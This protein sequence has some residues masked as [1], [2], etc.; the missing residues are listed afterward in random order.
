[1]ADGAVAGAPVL[2]AGPDRRARLRLPAWAVPPTL[3]GPVAGPVVLAVESAGDNAMDLLAAAVVAAE[4]AGDGARPFR[5]VVGDDQRAAEPA[6]ALARAAVAAGVDA[7][8]GHFSSP[9][10][11]AVAPIYGA[12]GIPFFAPGS[13]ANDLSDDPAAPVIQPFA[14]DGGQV[15]VLADAMAAHGG[16]AAIVAQTGNAGEA[17]GRA[18][19]ERLTA[20]GRPALLIPAEAGETAGV[21]TGGR[22]PIVAVLGSKEFA[23]DWLAR[24][25]ARGVGAVLLSDDSDGSTAVAA[26]LDR[27][28]LP[29][30]VATPASDGPMLVDGPVAPLRAQAAELLGRAPGPYFVSS[31]LAF[32]LALFARAAGARTA[33]E[34]IVALQ[35]R[36]WPSPFGLLRFD[37]MGRA[38]GFTWRLAPIGPER[39]P[40][41]ETRR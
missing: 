15:S 37:P 1:M 12:A 18:L 23:T 32:R 7:V 31:L 27:L 8:I 24:P 40:V 16:P 19:A 13:S 41:E 6:R 2:R 14:R 4:P 22:A 11:R 10:A 39:P 9:V 35:S 29:G 5:L 20:A 34:T 33:G 36:A 25:S 30:R 3:R 38:E 17:L 21:P 28:G 26:A